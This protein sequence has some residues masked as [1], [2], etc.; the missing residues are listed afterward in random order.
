[1]GNVVLNWLQPTVPVFVLQPHSQTIYQGS[2][3]TFAASAI[4]APD[5]TYQWRFNGGNIGSATSSNYT[6]NPVSTNDAGSYTVVASNSSGSV[7]SSV[8]V[9]TVPTSQAT[10]S[11]ATVTNHTFQFSISQVSGLSYAVQANTNLSTTNW[12]SIVTNTAPF[13]ITDTAFT[14]NQQRF[15]R[16]IYKP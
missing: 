14:N 4:G 10:L 2:S 1:M 7:T 8:A 9:L 13:T 15:Y 12:V 16:A 3:V 5:P 11:S 6:I